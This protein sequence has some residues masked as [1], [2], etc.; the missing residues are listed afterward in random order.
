MVSILSWTASLALRL[1]AT[2][3]ISEWGGRKIVLQ[4]FVGNRLWKS[5]Q[6]Q[7][8]SWTLYSILEISGLELVLSYSVRDWESV[9][10]PQLILVHNQVTHIPISHRV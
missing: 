5:L 10:H 8:A 7:R 4:G 3:Q 6:S 2:H 1:Y 9:M